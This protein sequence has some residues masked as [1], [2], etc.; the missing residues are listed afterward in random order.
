MPRIQNESPRRVITIFGFLSDCARQGTERASLWRLEWFQDNSQPRGISRLN[1]TAL[2]AR[3]PD[4]Y[5]R[6]RS[7]DLKMAFFIGLKGH[8]TFAGMIDPSH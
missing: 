6:S 4:H 1:Q 5:C 8:A 2:K 7:S 3:F